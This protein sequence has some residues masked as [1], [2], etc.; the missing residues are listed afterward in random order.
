MGTHLS[1]LHKSYDDYI[2]QS[3]RD[4][5]ISLGAFAHR[6]INRRLLAKMSLDF[7]DQS[8]SIDFF[9]YNRLQIMGALQRSF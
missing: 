1:Y 9:D 4:G 3:R 5:R 2:G 7:E 8:S 6:A